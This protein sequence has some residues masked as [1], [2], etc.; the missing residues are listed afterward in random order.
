LFS[1]EQR[2]HS[3]ADEHGKNDRSGRAPYSE[4]ET[5]DPRG[6]KDREH[7]DRGT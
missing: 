2:V 5:E 6:E 7:V 3:E 1:S 4:L